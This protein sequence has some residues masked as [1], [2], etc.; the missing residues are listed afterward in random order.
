[1][2]EY[3]TWVCKVMKKKISEKDQLEEDDCKD[4]ANGQQASKVWDPGKMQ[5]T[6]K[7]QSI[8]TNG[9]QQNQVWYLI[10]NQGANT[11]MKIHGQESMN[12]CTLGV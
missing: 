2:D 4:K 11:A 10:G 5:T 6:T 12:F 3:P 8:K 1:M 7:Q 9:K